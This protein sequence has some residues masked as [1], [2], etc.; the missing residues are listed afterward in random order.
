M[1]HP[2]TSIDLASNIADMAHDIWKSRHHL[3]LPL[4]L[5]YRID[6]TDFTEEYDNTKTFYVHYLIANKVWWYYTISDL[7][8][9]DIDHNELIFREETFDDKERNIYSRESY[10]HYA[11]SDLLQTGILKK[12]EEVVKTFDNISQIT[13]WNM[14]PVCKFT[15]KV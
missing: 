5:C 12:Y 7:S 9:Y 4:Y 14:F 6:V 10:R 2:K 11:F 8:Q 15:G 13:I 1:I 3:N